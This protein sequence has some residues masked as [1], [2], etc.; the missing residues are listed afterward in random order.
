MDSI[1]K[2]F[3]YVALSGLLT[4]TAQVSRGQ[5]NALVNTSQ[6]KFARLESPDLKALTWTNGFWA[7][8]FRVCRDSMVPHL[9]DTYT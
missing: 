1:T 2:Y 9:W 6:S 5:S 3:R 4:F 8:R 7:D